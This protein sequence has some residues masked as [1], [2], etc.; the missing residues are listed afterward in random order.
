MLNVESILF[1][2]D[3]P[4]IKMALEKYGEQLNADRIHSLFSIFASK[5]RIFLMS[6]SCKVILYN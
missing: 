3:N 5:R 6:G 1:D 4:R 2:T